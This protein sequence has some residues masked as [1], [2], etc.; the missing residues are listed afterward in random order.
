[1]TSFFAQ[2]VI[3][4]PT[5]AIVFSSKNTTRLERLSAG[6][7]SELTMQRGDLKLRVGCVDSLNIPSPRKTK[8][9]KV[10]TLS[11]TASEDG[12]KQTN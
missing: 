7:P 12:N 11:L 10:A 8:Y 9:F 6:N 3:R 4:A 1:M 5:D 2:L